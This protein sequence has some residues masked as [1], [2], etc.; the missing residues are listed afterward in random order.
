M[1]TLGV[2]KFL[3]AIELVILVRVSFG[4]NRNIFQIPLFEQCC[5]G[6]SKNL[7]ILGN[8]SSNNRLEYHKREITQTFALL[9][10]NDAKFADNISELGVKLY[11]KYPPETFYRL[12][13]AEYFAIAEVDLSSLKL[14]FKVLKESTWWNVYG[15]FVIQRIYSNSCDEAYEYLRMA[16][17]FNILS[18]IFVCMNSESKIQIHTFNPYSDYA[19]IVWIKYKSIRQ[20]NGHPLFLFKWVADLER[21]FLSKLSTQL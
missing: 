1:S 3:T 16:W 12:H 2:I 20:N 7:V 4:A 21:K 14:A 19:P 13:P 8:W 9:D 6:D 5:L 18:I 15:F 11:S 10:V 17:N